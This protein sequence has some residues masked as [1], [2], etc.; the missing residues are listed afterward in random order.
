M[1][2]GE[3]AGTGT[4]LSCFEGSHHKC[5]VGL[6]GGKRA[7]RE[8]PVQSPNAETRHATLPL[9]LKPIGFLLQSSSVYL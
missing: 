3:E 7:P 5:A 2:V 8:E 9:L 4:G 6:G 1:G